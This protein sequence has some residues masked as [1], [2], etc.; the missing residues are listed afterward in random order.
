MII[1]LLIFT[2]FLSWCSSDSR[3]IS[4]LELSQ[5]NWYIH[6]THYDKSYGVQNMQ[7]IECYPFF[8]TY[9]QAKLL[10][11]N[12]ENVEIYSIMF[13]IPKADRDD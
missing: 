3:Y 1:V 12:A 9:E 4:A 8:V 2:I 7:Q 10:Y 5:C 11:P 6:I 13:L